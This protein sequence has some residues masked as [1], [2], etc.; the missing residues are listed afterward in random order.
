MGRGRK[1]S[2]ELSYR[3]KKI[4][5]RLNSSFDTMPQLAKEYGISKQRIHQ[6]LL[7]AK[8]FG[9]VINRP[10]LLAR[11]HEIHRCEIC[12]RILQVPDDD[13]LITKRQLSHMLNI[14]RQ[15]CSWHLNQLK[16][17]GFISKKF[18]TMRSDRLAKAL[19]YYKSTS[20]TPGAVGRRFGYKNFY[21]LLNY[22]KKR[23]IA[24]ERTPNFPIPIVLEQ[25]S[26]SMSQTV[27]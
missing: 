1:P 23:G 7:R 27:S 2:K 14:E 6:I 21:S 25:E 20:L 15:V 16:A 13:A 8:D 9:Y 10:R 26:P 19:R 22:Q 11:Y 12:T 17:S 24:V 4:I 3:D 18:A 5:N